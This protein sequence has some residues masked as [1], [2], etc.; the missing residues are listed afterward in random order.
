MRQIKKQ[1]EKRDEEWKQPI[2]KSNSLWNSLV[3]IVIFIMFT[4]QKAKQN[5]HF[6]SP[7]EI[8]F[9]LTFHLP[10]VPISTTIGA[11]RAPLDAVMETNWQKHT[12][13]AFKKKYGWYS[14]YGLY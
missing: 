12:Y 7:D 5:S 2:T 11:P 13:F 1:E 14:T 3:Q 6:Y 9:S 4:V 8:E 10:W